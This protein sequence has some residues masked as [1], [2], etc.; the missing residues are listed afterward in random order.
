[1]DGDYLLSHQVSLAVP[2][3]VRSLTSVFGMG[4]GGTSS[5]LS[6]S[7]LVTAH[8]RRLDTQGWSGVM[9]TLKMEEDAGPAGCAESAQGQAERVIGTG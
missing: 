2:S 7:K 8:T 4:T 9:V 5:F 1:M 3:A 6:P